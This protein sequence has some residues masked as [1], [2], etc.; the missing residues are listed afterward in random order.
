MVV[1]SMVMVIGTLTTI[2]SPDTVE[3]QQPPPP[4]QI[5]LT[6][7][8]VQKIERMDTTLYVAALQVRRRAL[9]QRYHQQQQQISNDQNN[10]HVPLQGCGPPPYAALLPNAPENETVS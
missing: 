6:A 8:L 1:G 5:R 10:N 4:T 7:R 2:G 9:Y 3:A